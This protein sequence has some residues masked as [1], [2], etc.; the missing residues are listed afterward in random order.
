MCMIELKLNVGAYKNCRLCNEKLTKIIYP[1]SCLFKNVGSSY[2][3][4]CI[5]TEQIYGEI[6]ISAGTVE[7]LCK[8]ELMIL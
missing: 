2:R 7:Y 6:L 5:R 4:T 8:L 3:Y 1:L